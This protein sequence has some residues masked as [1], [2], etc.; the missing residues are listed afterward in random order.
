MLDAFHSDALCQID[1]SVTG[2]W[3]SGKMRDWRGDARSTD[4]VVGVVF[5]RQ[6][7]RVTWC[8]SER[9]N[10]EGQPVRLFLGNYDSAGRDIQVNFSVGDGNVRLRTLVE[11]PE[12]QPS[13]RLPITGVTGIL[14]PFATVEGSHPIDLF[15]LFLAG[16]DVKVGRNG[17]WHLRPNLVDSVPEAFRRLLVYGRTGELA[18][19]K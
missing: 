12:Y 14:L 10:P 19:A 7:T 11:S 2:A 5:C 17:L 16:S 18:A 3:R 6:G 9:A 1:V 13:I 8:K 15:V 4:P